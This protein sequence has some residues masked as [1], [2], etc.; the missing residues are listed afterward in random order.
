M[1]IYNRQAIAGLLYSDEGSHADIPTISHALLA[2]LFANNILKNEYI[3][4]LYIIQLVI[5]SVS[6]I[7]AS[8]IDC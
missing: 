7:F 5:Y 3:L 8:G 1:Y 4:V 6:I 2:M